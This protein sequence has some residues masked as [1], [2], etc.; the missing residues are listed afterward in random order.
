MEHDPFRPGRIG[1]DAHHL[2]PAVEGEVA[3]VL[4]EVF[5]D[6]EPA[7]PGIEEDRLGVLG[8]LELAHGVIERSSQGFG[9]GGA[10]EVWNDGKVAHRAAV[11]PKHRGGVEAAPCHLPFCYLDAEV[12][13]SRRKG[14]GGPRPAAG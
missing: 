14:R 8:E 1:L 5:P 2:P 12:R 7:A 10:V 11:F 9:V 13:S 4:S 3:V 6:C